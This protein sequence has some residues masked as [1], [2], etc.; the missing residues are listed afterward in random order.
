MAHRALHARPVR[1]HVPVARQVQR[2]VPAALHKHQVA[3]VVVLL[4]GPARGAAEV[5]LLLL[6][7][8]VVVV[9]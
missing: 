7:L 3:H 2:V 5:V 9:A 1:E 6:L 8:V 4:L